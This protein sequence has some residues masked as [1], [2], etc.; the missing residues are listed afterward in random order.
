MPL[1]FSFCY[2]LCSPSSCSSFTILPIVS[3]S[4]AVSFLLIPCLVTSYFFSLWTLDCSSFSLILLVWHFT[5]FWFWPPFCCFYSLSWIS[6]FYMSFLSL[7]GHFL[8]FFLLYV[9]L[10]FLCLSISLFL[11]VLLLFPSTHLGVCQS[12]HESVYP[13]SPLWFPAVLSLCTFFVCMC[14]CIPCVHVCDKGVS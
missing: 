11:S 8:S 2:C 13:P 10:C 4:H 7:L 12:V 3:E 5:F 6:L 9:F 1:I 14:V